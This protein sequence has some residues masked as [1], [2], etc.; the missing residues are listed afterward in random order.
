VPES[1]GARRPESKAKVRGA[2]RGP[3]HSLRSR[4]AEAGPRKRE[5][6]EDGTELGGGRRAPEEIEIMVAAAD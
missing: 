5:M 2:A 4:T 6:R 3:V 1:R